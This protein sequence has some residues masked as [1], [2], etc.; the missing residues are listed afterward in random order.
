[1]ALPQ[2]Y[3]KFRS[4]SFQSLSFFRLNYDSPATAVKALK[5][6]T[7]RRCSVVAFKVCCRH[8]EGHQESSG[9]EP[10]ESLFT[11]EMERRGMSP[12]SMLDDN[13]RSMLSLDENMKLKEDNSEL[14]KE[15]LGS[16]STDIDKSLSSQRERSMALNSE[17]LEGLIPRAKLLL[18]IGGTFFISFWPLVLTIVAL[19]SALY[20]YFGA[21]FI[22]EASK[23]PMA[24][25]PYID[26]HV[27]L[28]DGRTSQASHNVNYK[29]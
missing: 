10:P 3:L 18:T 1:M 20:L 21:S 29:K 23:A 17:G 7:R 14:S 19:L 28:E 24:T 16:T 22:H 15:N 12:T 5:L 27:L 26:P 25:P 13:N 2:S 4:D 6:Q 8:Q 11:K 9:E